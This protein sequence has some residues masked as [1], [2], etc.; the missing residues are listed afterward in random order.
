V[1]FHQPECHQDPDIPPPGRPISLENGSEPRNSGWIPPY[2]VENTNPLRREHSKQIGEIFKGQAHLWKQA[3]AAIRLLRTSRR[4][5][6]K[7]ILGAVPIRLTRLIVLFI[8]L[9]PSFPVS[10]VR[11]LFPNHLQATGNR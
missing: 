4:S 2:R 7:G 11:A 1:G 5:P 6:E 10:K 8:F 3:F 9:P